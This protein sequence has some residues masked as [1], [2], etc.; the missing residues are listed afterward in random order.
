MNAAIAIYDVNK[1]CPDIQKQFTD[2]CCT[3][4]GPAGSAQ[5]IICEAPKTLANP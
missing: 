5:C 1:E 2:S 3:A 4:A